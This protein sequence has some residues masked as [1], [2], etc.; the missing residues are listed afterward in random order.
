MLVLLPIPGS[1]LQAFYSSLFEIKEKLSDPDYTVNTPEPYNIHI[2]HTSHNWGV[3][4]SKLDGTFF[5][6][7]ESKHEDLVKLIRSHVSLFSD[8]PCI[9]LLQHDIDVGDSPL[10]KQHAYHVNP[11]KRRWL[12]EQVDYMV[13]NGRGGKST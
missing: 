10:I 7:A 12:Q 1:A 11:D 5:P 4:M 9:H 13:D 2:I 3:N 6:L 8:L